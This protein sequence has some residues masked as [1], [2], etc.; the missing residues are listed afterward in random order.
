MHINDL[1]S[2]A[3]APHMQA[4]NTALENFATA[5][6]S[7][8]AAGFSV[9]VRAPSEQLNLDD[10]LNAMVERRLAD[11][12]SAANLFAEL[13]YTATVREQA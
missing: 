10:P 11:V 1:I 6:S 2:Q 4:I 8:R 9:V 7:A 3:A 5:V 12:I 13:K